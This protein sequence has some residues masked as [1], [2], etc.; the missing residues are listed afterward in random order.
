MTAPQ[1]LV[2]VD[3]RVALAAARIGVADL[4]D[5][6]PLVEAEDEIEALRSGKPG[7]DPVT[8]LLASWRDACIEG[9]S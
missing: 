2:P 4:P 6:A 3:P 8:R 5:P 9:E 7:C 1:R